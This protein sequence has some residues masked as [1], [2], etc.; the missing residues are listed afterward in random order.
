VSKRVLITG[1]AGF[2]GRYLS[3]L[4]AKAGYEVHGL[5]NGQA[6]TAI[7]GMKTGHLADLRNVE[8]MCQ[9]VAEISPSHVVHL[10]AISFVAHED[11]SEIYE[12]NVVGTRN[13]LSA[14]ARAE[15]KP[16]AVLLTSSA[17]VYGNSDLGVLAEDDKVRPEN[18]YA[19]S[20][21]A[22]EYMARQFSDDLNLIVA[23]PFNYTGRGQSSNFLVP[24]IVN[25][26]RERAA[27]IELGNIDVSRD[28]ADVRTVMEYFHRLLETPGAAGNTYNICTGVPYSLKSIIET[29][30]RITGHQIE[31][32]INQAFVR[33]HEI[34][35]LVG[36]PA[37]LH[38]AVGKVDTYT[39]DT[40]LEW[41]LKA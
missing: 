35:S 11:V 14:L 39:F 17:N 40:T 27:R 7:A 34:K 26:F 16:E 36:N 37:K 21:I 3:P 32:S 5:T 22:M 1:I 25:H 29:C 15:K 33:P 24:K 19:V 28:F 13:L 4:L 12:T 38:S 10:A 8:Q 23:R 20:K 30:A 6:A 2:A 31:I 41:M 9:V 18:D